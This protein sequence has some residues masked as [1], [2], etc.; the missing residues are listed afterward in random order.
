MITQGAASRY[1]RPVITLVRAIRT[2]IACP[3]QWD[4]WDADGQYYYLRFRHG[5]GSASTAAS[6]EA[7]MAAEWDEQAKRWIGVEQVASF[8]T[9]DEFAVNTL[10]K[11]AQL[12]AI[13][14]SPDLDTTGFWR[15]IHN[16]LGEEFK[17]DPAA[18]A[19]A[20]QLL[21]AINLDAP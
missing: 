19:R 13:Q 5:Y 10:E 12:A 3:A 21:G 1:H 16:Q 2:S 17:N 11:F 8:E 20:D 9:E 14:L 7:F 18:L 15:N 4:A 6:P